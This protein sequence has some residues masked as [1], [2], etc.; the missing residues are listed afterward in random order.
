MRF[1]YQYE[2]RKARRERLD[3]GGG[4][5]VRGEFVRDPAGK[6]LGHAPTRP[7][8]RPETRARRAEERARLSTRGA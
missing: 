3:R 4:W 2:G 7:Y 8:M 6:V 5:I 1:P